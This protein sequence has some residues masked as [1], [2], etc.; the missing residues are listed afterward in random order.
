MSDKSP[1]TFAE[2]ARQLADKGGLEP[3]LEVIVELALETTGCDFASVTLVH[4]DGSVE[5]AACSH[6]IVA[7][8]DSLQY[9]LGEGPCLTAAETNGIYL[10]QDAEVD[11]RWPRWGPAVAEL[12]LRSVL[13]IHLFTDSLMLGALNLYA[14]ALHNYSADEVVTARVVA[15]HASVALARLRGEQDLWKAVDARHLV[16]Q[17]QG[18]LMERFSITSEQAFSVLR[19]YSQDH[20]IKLHDIAGRLVTT[21]Q[22]PDRAAD[23]SAAQDWVPAGRS[24]AGSSSAP[25][26]RNGSTNGGPGHPPVQAR[27][28]GRVDS[29]V[30]GAGDPAAFA[31]D[32]AAENPTADGDV[33]GAHAATIDGAAIEAEIEAAG[34]PAVD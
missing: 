32:G 31:A 21:G 23:R 3:A 22:L 11:N 8:A 20:N 1:L 2:R 24:P 16:G 29:K 15:A 7:Q 28:V 26:S 13:S 19:R 27:A 33:D 14:K 9:S 18:I 12:G 17:A 30:N 34:A 10:I 4:A 6:D 25:D 5:T